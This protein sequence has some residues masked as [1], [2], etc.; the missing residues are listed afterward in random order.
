MVCWGW[1]GGVK[2]ESSG[3][4]SSSVFARNLAIEIVGVTGGWMPR[5]MFNLS[6]RHCLKEGG[7]RDMLTWM[8]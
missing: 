1:V 6:Y 7:E 5:V 8:E 2:C 4:I 3:V